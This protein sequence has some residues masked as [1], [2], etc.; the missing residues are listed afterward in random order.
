MVSKGGLGDNCFLWGVP[1]C[2]IGRLGLCRVKHSEKNSVLSHSI[3]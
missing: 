3:P 2:G 1:L